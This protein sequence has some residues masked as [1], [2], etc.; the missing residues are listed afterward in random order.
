MLFSPSRPL[1]SSGFPAGK[2][3]YQPLREDREMDTK[4]KTVLIGDNELSRQ[5]LNAISETV[6]D[7]L[8][9]MGIEPASFAWHLEV[10]YTEAEG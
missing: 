4:L 1:W 7:A 3:K 2:V 9:D 5:E 8:R 10:E 6:H